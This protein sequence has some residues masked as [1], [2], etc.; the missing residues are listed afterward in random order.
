MKIEDFLSSADRS[1][2]GFF[3]ST[4]NTTLQKSQLQTELATFSAKGLTPTHK[5][6]FRFSWLLLPASR[7]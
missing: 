5:F 4:W 1:Q 6:R 3:R 2:T 7:K